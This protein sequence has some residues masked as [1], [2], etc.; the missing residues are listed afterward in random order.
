MHDIIVIA[1][2]GGRGRGSQAAE[3]AGRRDK[4]EDDELE[5]AEARTHDAGR[6]L[7]EEEVEEVP[8]LEAVASQQAEGRWLHQ[9]KV[10][11]RSARVCRIFST[12]A[13]DERPLANRTEDDGAAGL[14]GTSNA[15]PEAGAVSPALS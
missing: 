14:A 11:F 10:A 8:F 15:R 6:R 2:R 7:E 1:Q 12:M 5:K 3:E 13:S 9:D 4:L